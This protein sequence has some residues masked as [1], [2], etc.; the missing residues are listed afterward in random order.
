[1][2]ITPGSQRITRKDLAN[3]IE[4]VPRKW[5]KTLRGSVDGNNHG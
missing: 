2:S 4:W 1:M 3:V 5:F